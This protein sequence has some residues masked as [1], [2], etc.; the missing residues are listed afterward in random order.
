M[1]TLRLWWLLRRRG[2]VDRS[3][4]ARLTGA[5]AVI[6][7]AA[8]TAITLVVLGGFQAF[9][10]RADEG[11]Q[12]G[13]YDGWAWVL[14]A[15]FAVVLL[16]VPL[17]TLGGAAARLAMARR[18]ARLAALRLAGGTTGQAAGL[19]LLEAGAQ[20]ATGALVGIGGYLA[21]LPLVARLRFQDRTFEWHELWVGPGPLALAVLAIVLVA[22]VSAASSLARVAVTPLGVAARVTPPGL[23]AVR[24][25]GIAVVLAGVIAVNVLTDHAGEAI[26]I[27]AVLGVIGAGLAVV[28]VVGPWVLG[29]TGRIAAGTSRGVATLLAGRRIT[30]DPRT[31]WRSVGGVAL[32]TFIAGITS[33]VAMLPADTGDGSD[34][35]YLADIRTGGLLTLAIAG[36]LAGVSTG[37]MQ[38]GRV[39]DQRQSYRNLVLA[40]TRR[41]TLESARLRETVI[42][43]VAAMG[44]AAGMM[45]LVMVPLIGVSAFVQPA[46]LLQFVLSVLGAAGLVLLGAAASG[47]VARRVTT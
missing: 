43:L 42:P 30:D 17:T 22:L 38:A 31:A 1:T 14:L 34:A 44:T 46:V 10:R 16:L 40:G 15:G 27:G 9:L 13:G 8:T 35:I 7:F 24:L 6:A 47:L 18:D 36:L 19:T 25:V 4:P 3:D 11:L 33:I 26:A 37:V 28:N 5:L 32:A 23:R 39:I 29:L 21:L 20:A 41:R 12:L 45:L 2:G